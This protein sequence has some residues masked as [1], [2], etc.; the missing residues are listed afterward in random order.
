M[1]TCLRADVCS[2]PPGSLTELVLH[3]HGEPLDSNTLAW[4]TKL[5][6]I[7]KLDL[8][9]WRS[10]L[11][12]ELLAQL[13]V[14]EFFSDQGNPQLEHLQLLV[15]F[16]APSFGIAALLLN[17]EWNGRLLAADFDMWALT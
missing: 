13:P 16:Q 11:D 6:A 14:Q 3:G 7:R 9:N 5:T 4:L 17:S 8:C 12:M 15:T 1:I 10:S 2:I